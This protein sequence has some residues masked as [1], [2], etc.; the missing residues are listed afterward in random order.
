MTF[1]MANL[2]SAT[3]MMVLFVIFVI[4]F[5]LVYNLL[6]HPEIVT[7][8]INMTPQGRMASMASMAQ[9]VVAPT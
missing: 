7:S 3:V 1:S 6:A 5:A 4:T 8:V 2:P 9:G